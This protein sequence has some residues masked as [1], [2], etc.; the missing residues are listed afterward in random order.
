MDSQPLN[1]ESQPRTAVSREVRPKGTVEAHRSTNSQSR[2]VLC[3]KKTQ[4]S[5]FDRFVI[6]NAGNIS[7]PEMWTAL[8][9]LLSME[10]A[11]AVGKICKVLQKNGSVRFD[12]WV[13]PNAG[14]ALKDTIRA[15][16]ASCRPK[17]VW[18]DEVRCD[19]PK[20]LLRWRIDVW[21]PWRDR[22]IRK[23][24][25]ENQTEINVTGLMTIN[26][27]GIERKLEELNEIL[28]NEKIAV[29]AVQETLQGN[30]CYVKC[31]EGYRLFGRLKKVGFRGQAIL[32]HRSLSAYEDHKSSSQH[33]IH[34]KVSGFKG[35]IGSIH[36]LGVYLP[37]GGN[38]RKSRRLLL[39]SLRKTID[40]IRT[41]EPDV[42][43]MI[44]GDFNATADEITKTINPLCGVE[45]LI[46]RGKSTSRF[47]TSGT[48]SAIDHILT[49]NKGREYF[50]RPRV[51]RKYAISDHRPVVSQLRV[52]H[53]E[54]TMESIRYRLDLNL[55]RG[56]GGEI[57]NDESWEGL[58]NEKIQNLEDLNKFAE[59]F[60]A[61]M[62]K[63]TMKLGVKKASRPG[64][65]L[66]PRHLK[67]LLQKRN[68]AR[69]VVEELHSENVNQDTAW[70]KANER[71]IFLSEQFDKALLTWK[72]KLKEKEVAYVC[73]DIRDGSHKNLW[74]RIR[75]LTGTTDQDSVLSPVRN[76]AGQLCTTS[77]SIRNAIKEHYERLANGDLSSSK[78]HEY[79]SNPELDTG[80]SKMPD[81]DINEDLTWPEVLIAIRCMSVGTAAAED[82]IHVNIMKEILA[83]ECRAE[84]ER[85]LNLERE[86]GDPYKKAPDGIR[87]A[88]PADE[89]PLEPGTLLGKSFYALICAS[90][91][92]ERT[93]DVWN[94]VDVVNL[95]KSKDPELLENY[96][97]I[98]LLSVS[99]KVLLTLMGARI[100]TAMDEMGGIVSEQ[101]GYR[102]NEE[103]IAQFIAVADVVRRR[104][105]MEEKTFGVFIDFKKAFDK[106]LHEALFRVLDDVG[107]RGKTLNFIKYIY[108]NAQMRVKVGNVSSETFPM[109][110]GT[111]QGCPISPLLF[112]IFVNRIFKDCSAAGTDVKNSI[113][114]K[115]CQYA[116]DLLAF[117]KGP[118]EAKKFI[119]QL[120]IWCKKWGMVVNIPKSGVMAWGHTAEELAKV[121]ET[122]ISSSEGNFPWV[123]EYKYLGI[124]TKE[125][126]SM[127]RESDGNEFSHAK[128]LAKKAQNT[129]HVIRPILHDPEY[130]LAVKVGLIKQLLIP[131]GSFGTEWIGFKASNA[132][133]V[134]KMIN[135]AL[136]LVMGHRMSATGALDAEIVSY[137]LNV[138][139]IEVVQAKARTRLFAKL[140]AGRI[141][142]NLRILHNLP[143]KAS[144]KTWVTTNNKWMKTLKTKMSKWKC[145]VAPHRTWR[146][147]G[148]DI[149][150]HNRSNSYDS[151]HIVGYDEIVR[152]MKDQESGKVE[153]KYLRNKWYQTG[154]INLPLERSKQVLAK[155][156]KSSFLETEEICAVEDAIIEQSMLRNTG[157][158][159]QIYDRFEIGATRDWLIRALEYPEYVKEA[160]ALCTVR[161]LS[162]R[163][164][165]D[166][167]QASKRLGHEEVRQICPLCGEKVEHLMEWAHLLTECN[168]LMVETA[169]R[170]YI[171]G[172][173][174][175]LRHELKDAPFLIDNEIGCLRETQR[176]SCEE[177]IQA[178]LIGGCIDGFETKWT[179][180]FGH[181]K[182]IAVGSKGNKHGWT[183]VAR[184]LYEVLPRYHDA[185]HLH[186][187]SA[188]SGIT[189]SDGN[190][191][192]IMDDLVESINGRPIRNRG[193][194]RVL[195]STEDGNSSIYW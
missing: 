130:P 1:R 49:N 68:K 121:K 192:S 106:V 3:P 23:E 157:Q 85:K 115:G 46:P 143:L 119:E 6:F 79:W 138:P 22:P 82:G 172:D 114:L 90:W 151:E 32:V 54:P 18:G 175:R 181:L 93:P 65:P 48:P 86:D 167:V 186:I 140:K 26:V 104:I 5:D 178:Y 36:V 17:H 8:R 107:I 28:V 70:H 71:L 84:I 92:F 72:A 122:P 162:Y 91:Q 117:L 170:T 177:A 16:R 37:S 53:L 125:N 161:T 150:T 89:L 124:K 190:N 24:P 83:Y 131:I 174:I 81:L 98:S 69:V 50:R 184:F 132:A 9:R 40:R 153:D 76:K 171:A 78:D 27:N 193:A 33:V 14:A 38:F 51:L 159:F 156:G 160:Q 191:K 21:R 87:F 142:T 25:I 163:T 66:F 4:L 10:A 95:Y 179:M 74:N 61:N 148:Q 133:P 60:N 58:A 152:N 169:R 59:N 42:A 19:S 62:H 101:A 47:P 39:E 165:Q 123:E 64:K 120:L 45:V 128:D 99:L 30:G 80:I 188:P 56:H 31:P 109:G 55:V 35:I 108:T 57:V 135:E 189:K 168:H 100:M 105:I 13:R 154:T 149:E 180:G 116:D 141:R 137:E 20:K 44:L 194:R 139:L 67:S 183:T 176:Y 97:G 52:M 173:I 136:R 195:L 102:K 110:R 34:I 94:L 113:A 15:N 77:E 96:R 127:S 146:F 134:Q 43:I 187:E 73:K 2:N 182:E 111:R 166:T 118:K 11:A 129:L 41:K 7:V 155:S 126:L 164:V 75:K 88:L 29:C 185:L 144:T 147:R 145:P 158:R 12:L 63:L 112:I 103:A